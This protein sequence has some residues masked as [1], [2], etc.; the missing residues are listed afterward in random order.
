MV[1]ATADV[2]LEKNPLW[3]SFVG[4]AAPISS[5]LLYM[6]PIPTVHEFTKRKMVGSLPLLPYTSMLSNSFAWSVYG[7][8]NSEPKLWTANL[9]GLVLSIYYFLSFARYTPNGAATLPGTF[10]QHVQGFVSVLAFVLWFARNKK[11]GPIGKVGVLINMA[12]YASPLAAIKAVLETKSSEAI[13]LPLTV[14]SL[15]SC[16]FW[17]ITGY[18]DMHD[19][20]VWIPTC[21]GM[22]FG[23]AQVG[24]K[25]SFPE[26]GGVATRD[27]SPELNSTEMVVNVPKVIQHQ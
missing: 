23:L 9:I 13:P 26:K 21:F 4:K 27:L 20:Y 3:L 5:I 19:P 16:V 8:M 18:L 24:L 17:T 14:A 7:L 1:D 15:A 25:I 11:A 10:D 22:V 2:L 12:M 6:A